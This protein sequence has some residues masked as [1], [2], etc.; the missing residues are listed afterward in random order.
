MSDL[1]DQGYDHLAL[2]ARAKANDDL[3][4]QQIIH[5][6]E[7]E[8]MTLLEQRNNKELVDLIMTLH[9]R[10]SKCVDEIF[11]LKNKLGGNPSDFPNS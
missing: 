6:K 8:E 11:K 1:C 4:F 9:S 3:I 7:L 5:I 10:L 2:D